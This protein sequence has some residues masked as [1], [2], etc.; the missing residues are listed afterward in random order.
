[1][2]GIMILPSECARRTTAS[3]NQILGRLVMIKINRKALQ[4]FLNKQAQKLVQVDALE[5]L[6]NTLTRF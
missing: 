1:M 4:T 6:C 3:A 2:P 5:I